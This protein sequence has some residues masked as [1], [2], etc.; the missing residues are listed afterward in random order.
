MY[1]RL[2]DFFY[3]NKVE[4]NGI[5]VLLIILIGLIAVNLW[6]S[7]QDQTITPSSKRVEEGLAFL[8]SIHQLEIEKRNKP[9]IN[10]ERNEVEMV[11]KNFNPN[12]SSLEDFMSMGLT[13]KQANTIINYRNKGGA[14]RIKSDFKKMYSISDLMYQQLEAYILLPDTLETEQSIF[15]SIEKPREWTPPVVYINSSDSADF[16]KLRGIGPTYA[17]RIIKY[18]NRL[19]GFYNPNQLSEVY[20]LSDSLIRTF[21]EQ[22]VFDSMPIQKLNV[23]I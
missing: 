3:F 8:D 4:R 7:N 16:T 23:N 14:F 17:S 15:E 2:K 11:P 13:E 18:R 9:S 12:I 5:I 22:L 10:K 6:L 19:G 21:E 20:G 1:P